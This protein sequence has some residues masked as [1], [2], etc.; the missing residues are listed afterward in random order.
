MDQNFF[1]LDHDGEFSFPLLDLL[2]GNAKNLPVSSNL[3]HHKSVNC[4]KMLYSY[5]DS[6]H[7]HEVNGDDHK[8]MT[9]NHGNDFPYEVQ[10]T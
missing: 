5:L 7:C 9:S 3:N 1:L 10:N 4:K 6:G 8:V 2:R